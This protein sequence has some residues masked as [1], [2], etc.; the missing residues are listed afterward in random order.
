MDET[1]GDTTSPLTQA[2]ESA[3]E[4]GDLPTS[5]MGIHRGFYWQRIMI[6]DCHY[7]CPN[8]ETA[9]TPLRALIYRIIVPWRSN[10]VEEYGRSPAQEPG[11]K[12][13]G[14]CPLNRDLI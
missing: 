7:G 9:L 1:S 8:V 13:V 5:M 10:V 6:E 11:W 4:K 12:R 2:I 3:I 14:L